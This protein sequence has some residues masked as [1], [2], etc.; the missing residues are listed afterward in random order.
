MIEILTWIAFLHLIQE[1]ARAYGFEVG[2]QGKVLP[3]FMS[4]PDNPFVH[5][6]RR[7]YGIN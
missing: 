5:D 4:S 6:W 7:I 1:N 3:K 2:R